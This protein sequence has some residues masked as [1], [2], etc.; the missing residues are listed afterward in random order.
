MDNNISQ[1]LNE[2]VWDTV[3]KLGEDA[4]IP[5]SLKPEY[6]KEVLQVIP[7]Q[8]GVKAKG[9]SAKEIESFRRILLKT[10][11]ESMTEKLYGELSKIKLG[12]VV[13]IEEER[14]KQRKKI[15]EEDIE[16][17]QTL[18]VLETGREIRVSNEKSNV[19]LEKT[20][21]AKE[22]NSLLKEKYKQKGFHYRVM[23]IE[24]GRDELESYEYNP[25]IKRWIFERENFYWKE[26][27]CSDDEIAYNFE[28]F[29]IDDDM[30]EDYIYDNDKCVPDDITEK[31]IN[32]TI[33]ELK[34][35]LK[36]LSKR[37]ARTKNEKLYAAT[38]A[39]ADCVQVRSNQE[40]RVVYD[41]MDFF[42]FINMELK[43]QW[44]KSSTRYPEIQYIKSLFK[45]NKFYVKRL[46]KL[47]F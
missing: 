29:T 41:C 40:Y 39:F 30:I 32:E 31:Q 6:G 2:I 4:F 25:D 38:L 36:K 26:F 27:C 11:F 17:A 9:H 35:E 45:S 10:P 34:I 15:L 1:K 3:E 22:F 13:L 5:V 12:D 20:L 16:L 44:R 46:H 24:E 43:E 7:P 23:S 14:R 18:L 37:G 8:R 42:G 28:D 33:K 21:I 19:K 47:P